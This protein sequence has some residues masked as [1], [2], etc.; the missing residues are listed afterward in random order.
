[1]ADSNST[2]V[3]IER[4]Q[5]GDLS[6]RELLYDR[7]MLPVLFLVRVS[8]GRKL[9]SKVESWDIV[10]ETLL[11][12]LRDLDDFRPEHSGAFHRYLAKKVDQVIL[13]HVDYWSAAKRS[14]DREE[15]LDE[16]VA[17]TDDRLPPRQTASQ[18]PSDQLILNEDLNHLAEAMDELAETSPD[19]WDVIVAIKLLGGSLRDVA[20]SR[21]T[22]PDAVKMKQRRAMLKL[23]KI[24]RIQEQQRHGAHRHD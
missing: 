4:V 19:D 10:Q 13:D 3:L 21:G 9:R 16:S 15:R 24:F 5:Q 12:S 22:S 23:A 11:R 14:M 1:M 17:P 6:A 8:L 2:Q 18:S 7:C 20:H